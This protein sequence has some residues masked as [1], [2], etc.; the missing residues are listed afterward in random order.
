[1]NKREII[2]QSALKLFVS[3]GFQDTPTAKITKD[4]GVATGTL[5]QYFK[6]KEDLILTL[7][8]EVKNELTNYITANTAASND[9][10]NIIKAQFY[11]SMNW[12]LKNVDKF[13]Y[14]RQVY[15][16]PYVQQI[17]KSAF[18][19]HLDAHYTVLKTGIKK[20]E[21]KNLPVEYLYSIIS[22]QTFG[23]FDYLCANKLSKKEKE[24]WILITFDLLWEILK[25]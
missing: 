20:K 13:N 1:M 9:T 2:L 17:D 24:K 3:L 22:S 21:I 6:S 8:V 16:S 25:K 12:A 4:A 14:I 11:A 23:L 10:K 18:I 5:F 15:H 19:K 7:F